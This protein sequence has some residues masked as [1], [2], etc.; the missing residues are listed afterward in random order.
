VLVGSYAPP[1][2]TKVFVTVRTELTLFQGL[3]HRRRCRNRIGL[4][5]GRLVSIADRNYSP[6]QGQHCIVFILGLKLPPSV[7]QWDYQLGGSY[8]R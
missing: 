1:T 4:P 3:R 8:T 7:T 2:G 5:A 6:D